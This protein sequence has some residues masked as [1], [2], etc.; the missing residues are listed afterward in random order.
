MP[1]HFTGRFSHVFLAG[2]SCAALP[3]SFSSGDFPC[4]N[5]VESSYHHLAT[6]RSHHL[7]GARLLSLPVQFKQALKHKMQLWGT[8]LLKECFPRCCMHRIINMKVYFG[9][10]VAFPLCYLPLPL[11]HFA[12]PTF[13]GTHTHSPH[14]KPHP[15]NLRRCSSFSSSFCSPST[16]WGLSAAVKGSLLCYNMWEQSDMDLYIYHYQISDYCVVVWNI[17]NHILLT[18][19]CIFIQ[20]ALS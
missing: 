15:I 4:C 17:T 19:S 14:L 18:N 10:R 5:M 12:Q 20:A 2:P 13:T 1:V 6:P 9:F 7:S 16:H 11:N 8:V 3:R